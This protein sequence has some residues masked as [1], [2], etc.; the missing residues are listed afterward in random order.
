MRAVALGAV[1]VGAF[2]DRQL[3]VGVAGELPL[4][5]AAVAQRLAV[6]GAAHVGGERRAGAV[7]LVVRLR[8]LR[9]VAVLA[10][11]VGEAGG[12][13]E[14]RRGSASSCRR[15]R[16]SS[17]AGGHHRGVVGLVVDAVVGRALVVA[18]GVAG[19]AALA[20]VAGE[21]VT[22]LVKISAWPD[23]AHGV[24]L[25][26]SGTA[27]WHCVQVVSTVGRPLRVLAGDDARPQAG[28][29]DQRHRC[30]GRQVGDGDGVDAR[31]VRGELGA[32]RRS[33][34]SAPRSSVVGL[35][36]AQL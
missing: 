13:R 22:L 32:L 12:V 5:E 24:N 19:H 8:V 31:D 17:E 2:L 25:S 27:V 34:R 18:D 26:S 28:V 21:V 11:D 10:L 15:R 3:V 35:A 16:A 29:D 33:A 14:L 30:V 7:A 36:S 4:L 23:C 20:V 6:A 1:P 9:A